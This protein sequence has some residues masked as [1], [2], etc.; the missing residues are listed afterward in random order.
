MPATGLNHVSVRADD[1]EESVRFY[2]EVFGAERLP[3]YAFGFPVQYLKLGDLELHIFQ[4]GDTS[5]SAFHHFGL[6]VDDFEHVYLKARD[7]DIFDR[8]A[9][10]SHVYSVPNGSVRMYLRDPADNLVEVNWSDVSTLDR[11][12]V[13]EIKR[14][15]DWLPQGADAP[16]ADRN[17]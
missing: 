8:S 13:G 3:T 14:L 17:R 10:F 11:S 4:R 16:R 1:L 12:V 9:F 2:E 15:E 7:L 5:V 6:N